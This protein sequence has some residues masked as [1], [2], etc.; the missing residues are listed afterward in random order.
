MVTIYSAYP[1]RLPHLFFSNFFSVI[2]NY[3][4]R[5]FPLH[6]MVEATPTVQIFIHLQLDILQIQITILI[7][8]F[9][10]MIGYCKSATRYHI[11]ATFTFSLLRLFWSI[12]SN[13]RKGQA[14]FVLNLQMKPWF[15]RHQ[16]MLV[17]NSNS[18]NLLPVA[19]TEM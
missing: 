9:T 8:R 2:N 19:I 10:L 18:A 12:M 15:F 14:K 11:S 4:L 3:Y 7:S 1:T 6:Q 17:G 16:L 13:T 5:F